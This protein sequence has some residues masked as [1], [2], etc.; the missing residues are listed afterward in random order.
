MLTDR[1]AALRH[2]D[3]FL[4]E[5][6]LDEAIAQYLRL[7]DEQ[8]ADWNPA[9]L[10]GDLETPAGQLEPAIEQFTRIAEHL[11]RKGFLPAAAALYKRVLQ[12]RPDADH[13]LMMAGELAA[14]QGLLAGAR[15]YFSTA[16]EARHHRGDATGALEVIARI[17]GLDTAG[18]EDRRAGASD[19]LALD[20]T[21]G[22]SLGAGAQGDRRVVDTDLIVGRPESDDAPRPVASAPTVS[23]PLDIEAVF[24]Q[25]RGEAEHTPSDR[26]AFTRGSVMFEVGETRLAIEELRRAAQSPRRRFAAASLLARIHQEQGR[27][28]EAIEWLRHAVDAPELTHLE[29]F[30]ALF[31]LA[32]LLEH[33]GEPAS[34][35]A[36]CLELQS[37]AGD[38]RDLT[39]RIAR[40]L[41][42]SGG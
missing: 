25:L 16:A 9:K 2:A 5:G 14:E 18:L 19:S 33:V 42:A 28:G 34:A 27:D 20:E 39:A 38:Y 4:R 8:P 35:L 15:T 40:L 3:V 36:V 37:T 23:T 13:A 6:R 26:A 12:I 21:A 10:L 32:D 30:D 11:R 22:T 24:E 1:A 31:R 41:Q 17:R 29:R 7:I